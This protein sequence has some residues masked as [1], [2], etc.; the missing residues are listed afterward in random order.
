MSTKASITLKRESKIFS[1]D[2]L[3]EIQVHDHSLLGQ[4][5]SFVLER[6]VDVHDRRAVNKSDIL[7]ARKFVLSSATESFAIPGEKLRA[8]SYCGGK[9]SI[10]VTTKLIIDDALIFDTKVTEEHQID[11]GMK[12][13]VPDNA[14]EIVEP[15]DLFSFLQNLKAIPSH[16]QLMTFV[17]LIVGVVIITA[18]TLVGV[19]DQFVPE[20]Q[21]YVYSH[22]DS[23]GDAQSPL[24][25]SLAGSGF[26]GFMVWMAIKRQLRKYMIFELKEL[27]AP[28]KP[29]DEIEIADLVTGRSRV[30]LHDVTLRVVAC[31]ME[32]GQYKR[33]HGTQER[34]VSFKEPVRGLVLFE[35]YEKQVRPHVSITNYFSGS[36][37]FD[38]MF[39]VLYPRQM[40]S[41]THGLD[42]HWEV[43]LIHPDFVD[44]ELVGPNLIFSH[45]D[46]LTA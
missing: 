43:Q 7:C 29:G 36:F 18:N 40:I 11:I 33:G 1:D 25:N 42:L 46:F 22:R 16:N 3:C 41:S 28:V 24:F 34:T 19:H 38:E 15:K 17:L 13:H 23:D 10:N 39:S 4:N 5:A 27:S 37:T 21:T 2:L 8:F 9:I 30:P 31:N 20:Y 6:E 44:Q 14:K 26:L 32:C 12:P 45:K 35:K